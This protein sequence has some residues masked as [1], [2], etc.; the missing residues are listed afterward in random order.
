[1]IWARAD[2]TDETDRTDREAA[3]K[4][5]ARDLA[6]AEGH[7]IECGCCFTEEIMVCPFINSFA[8]CLRTVTD[9]GLTSLRQTRI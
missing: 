9:V 6:L 2:L 3:E 7:G 4:A 8:C 1:M 5:A